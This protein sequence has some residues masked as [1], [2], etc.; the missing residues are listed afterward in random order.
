[1]TKLLYPIIA[2]LLVLFLSCSYESITVDREEC[3]IE[4]RYN[5]NVKEIING[6]CAFHVE[7]HGAN[8]AYGDYTTYDRMS[9]H[10][11]DRKFVDRVLVIR[12]MPPDYAHEQ[13]GPTQLTEEQIKILTCWV[14]DDYPQ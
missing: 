8:S 6:S 12:N 5:D 3:L 9:I 7:C 13:G 14:Q 1:M 2:V 10:L 11:T 4:A